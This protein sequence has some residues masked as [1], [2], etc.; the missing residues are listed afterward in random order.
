MKVSGSRA[1]TRFGERER[2]E[3]LLEDAREADDAR[4]CLDDTVGAPVDELARGIPRAE[5]RADFAR[6]GPPRRVPAEPRRRLEQDPGDVPLVVVG[7]PVVIA[8][9]RRSTRRQTS[10]TSRGSRS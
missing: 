3:V 7:V 8:R 1:F 9:A 6:S 2:C 4:L 5:D 10:A